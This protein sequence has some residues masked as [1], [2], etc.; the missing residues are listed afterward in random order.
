[1]A[2]DF[3]HSGHLNLIKKASSYGKV[4][5]GLLTDNAISEYKK[6]PVLNYK[7][8]YN[9]ISNIK[10][11]T[12]IY[13]QEDRDYF[14]AIKDIKPNYFLHGDDWKT[15]IQKKIRSNVIKELKKIN[16]KLIEVPYTKN[17]S[18][19]LI[20]NEISK[21]L[22]P[23]NRVS[24]L[25]RLMVSKKCIRILEAHTPLSALI[26]EKIN[27][28]SKNELL[29]FD[30]IWSSSLTDSSSRGKPDNQS[31]DYSTRFNGLNEILDVTTKPILFDGD[32]GGQLV[33]LPYMV[34]TLERMGVS[35]LCLEDKVG[36]KSNSLFEDQRSN[37]QDSIKRFSKKIMTACKSRLSNYFMIVARI[38]SFILG[39]NVKDALKRAEAYSSAG[40][41]A[42]LI[43]SKEKN[44]KQIF[45]F[46]KI[47]KKSKFFKPII[48]V[49]STY[50]QISIKNIKKN[51]IN[52]VI[53]ANHMLRASYPA[54]SKVA[55][56]ILKNS[57]TLESEKK[58][59]SI[60]EIINLFK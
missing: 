6:I 21:I 45:E 22:T 30:A 53:Y 26:A 37:K 9:L 35:G 24:L 28:Q 38:E 54:M 19:T 36:L 41:D 23:A 1:M 50:P 52:A 12:R 29:E 49:P 34:K 18:S 25:A 44:P 51:N 55:E 20:K 56:E 32:N 59:I 15:G 2:V 10:G 16:S 31:V 13:K 17:I 42:I 48:I 14:K 60:K 7:E 4:I 58:L 27:Y 40:A 47:F 39:K 8:R 5:I 3:L 43:H 57:R 33:H 11:I 46:S